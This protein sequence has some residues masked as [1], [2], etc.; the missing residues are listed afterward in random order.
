MTTP[1]WVAAGLA[2]ITLL[3]LVLF[4]IMWQVAEPNEALIVSGSRH[5][6]TGPDAGMGF[7]IVTGRGTLVTPFVHVAR[8]LSLDLNET[9]LSVEC[10]T[11]QG[12]PVG[13]QGVVVFKVGDDP[14]SIA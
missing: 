10:V 13:V 2:G 9:E 3:A 12:I 8:K 6:A 5:A 1:L 7:R 4:K 11:H 14:V